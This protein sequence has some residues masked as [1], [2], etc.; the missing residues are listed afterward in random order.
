[1]DYQ[2]LKW[3]IINEKP[4]LNSIFENFFEEDRLIKLSEPIILEAQHALNVYYDRYMIQ[5]NVTK[6]NVI[7]YEKLLENLK[8]RKDKIFIYQINT[9]IGFISCFFDN[10]E[11]TL[12]GVLWN[13]NKKGI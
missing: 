7:G 11:K 8:N 3:H 4:I 13:P 12:L 6:A 5:K 10:K 1:M 2:N 9:E